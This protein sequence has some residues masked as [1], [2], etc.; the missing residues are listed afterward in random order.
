MSSEQI[1]S[2]LLLLLSL[3][4]GGR[5]LQSC[6][7]EHELLPRRSYLPAC[8]DTENEGPLLTESEYIA[9][10]VDCELAWFTKDPAALEAQAIAAR[11]FLA[12]HLARKGE[13]TPLPMGPRFQCWRSPRPRAVEA[14]QLTEDLILEHEGRVIRANYA[15]GT[16]KLSKACRALPPQKSGYRFKSWGEM[17]AYYKRARSQGRRS[18][19]K[20]YRWTEILV[21]RNQGRRGKAVQ[22]TIHA[23]PDAQNRG[24]FGQYAAACLAKKGYGTFQILRYFYGED[25]ELAPPPEFGSGAF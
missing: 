13:D 16:P 20:G 18:I 5:S 7:R 24:G 1:I 4:C 8:V 3:G 21:T 12:A 14:A 6:L 23:Q 15:S 19:F 11:T 17:R 25:V 9:G 2:A 10:V 22:A